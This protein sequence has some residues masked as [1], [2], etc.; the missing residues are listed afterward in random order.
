MT[1]RRVSVALAALVMFAAGAAHA[2]AQNTSSGAAAHFEIGGGGVF[3]GGSDL[4]NRTA[5]LTANTGTTGSPSTFFVTDSRLTSSSGVQGHLAVFVTRALAIEG[6]VRLSRPTF[7]IRLSED[8]ES[9]PNV[10]AEEKITQYVFDGS[11]VWHFKDGVHDKGAVPFIFGG[12]GYFREL[13]DEGALVE[14]GP[15]YHAGGGV[16]WWLGWGRTLGIRAEAGI[17]VRDNSADVENGRHVVPIVAGSLI[18]RF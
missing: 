2:A 12:V 5:E 8:V 10:T 9:A 6:G 16:K 4:G 7:Q 18:W 11:A 15:E 17:S 1:P 14:D 3:L 13:H